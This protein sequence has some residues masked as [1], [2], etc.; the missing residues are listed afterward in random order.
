MRNEWTEKK[1]QNHGGKNS[2][3]HQHFKEECF[4]FSP[5][6]SFDFS[7]NHGNPIYEYDTN[8]SSSHFYPL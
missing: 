6:T 8:K 1:R 7:T 2:I 3:K 5:E 4:S